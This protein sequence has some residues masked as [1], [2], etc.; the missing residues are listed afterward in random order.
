[1][2]SLVRIGLTVRKILTI[3]WE[4]EEGG[5]GRRRKKVIPK[6]RLPQRGIWPINTILCFYEWSCLQSGDT[7]IWDAHL[8]RL[9][10]DDH[11]DTYHAICYRDYR[12]DCERCPG[13]NRGQECTDAGDCSDEMGRPMCEC[14]PRF[15]G[16]QCQLPRK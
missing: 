4:K 8:N 10:I 6:A 11:Y 15:E 3:V 13:F 2:Q 14:D 12:Q 1:M 7:L 5:G 9:Y 16:D